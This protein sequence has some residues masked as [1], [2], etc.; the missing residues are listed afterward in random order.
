MRPGNSDVAAQL[1][2]RLAGDT[3][4]VCRHFLP[5]GRRSGN[6][7]IVGDVMGNPGRSMFVRLRKKGGRSCGRWTDAATGEYGDLLD[8]IRESMGLRSFG[9][10]LE[11]ARRFLAMP[12]P[13]LE[14]RWVKTPAPTGSPEAS[15][16]LFAASRPI[17]G[18]LVQ[19]Y[20]ANRGID[21]LEG[22]DPLRF[23]PRCWHRLEDGRSLAWPA[24]IAAVTDLSGAIQGV[25]RTWLAREQNACDPLLGKAPFPTPRRAMGSLF[26]HG[27]RFGRPAELLL[28]GEGIE[29]VL[30]LR[31][32][33]P[34][35]PAAAALSAGNLRA[36]V[37]PERLRRLYVALERDGESAEAFAKLAER[38]RAD[39]IDV[40]G[41][42]PQLGDSND[43]LRLLGRDAL[44]E[45]LLA[46]LEPGDAARFLTR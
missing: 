38:S 46:Q 14:R 12:L 18:T 20:L 41:L 19:A 30:S 39:G 32:L 9:E 36:L 13:Q 24:I 34:A 23:H 37:L 10:T 31:C 15:F 29:T 33:M 27:V 22:C 44:R 4:A 2:E 42:R 43:D 1:N 7:W 6:Y 17:A 45:R 3:E 25:H 16:R 8:I 35:L 5:A 21:R 26:G 11:E 28:V 40:V